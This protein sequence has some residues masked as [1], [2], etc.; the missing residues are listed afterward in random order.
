M[1]CFKARFSTVLGKTRAFNITVLRTLSLCGEH[2]FY[3]DCRCF[4][5]RKLLLIQLQFIKGYY[6][7]AAEPRN[8]CRNQIWLWNRKRCGA[9]KYY[10]SSNKSLDERAFNF[11]CFIQTC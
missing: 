7:K 5:P 4:A 8:L 2:L 6:F 11:P 3:K 1:L 10:H 9:P